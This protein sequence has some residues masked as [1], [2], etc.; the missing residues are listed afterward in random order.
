MEGEER[1][2]AVASQLHSAIAR[3]PIDPRDP[4][5]HSGFSPTIAGKNYRE[6]FNQSVEG[7]RLG[8]TRMALARRP[9]TPSAPVTQ[10]EFLATVSEL[11]G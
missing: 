3:A 2:V 6:A 11:L 4:T 1:E 9:T 10:K 5:D 8:G 7:F